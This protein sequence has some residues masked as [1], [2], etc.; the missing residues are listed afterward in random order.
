VNPPGL[1]RRELLALASVMTVTCRYAIRDVE[2]GMNGVEREDLRGQP[3]AVLV[4]GMH[5]SG[6]ALLARIIALLSETA[7]RKPVVPGHDGIPR[8]AVSTAVAA[9]NRRMLEEIGSD[10]HSPR[11]LFLPGKSIAE[12]TPVIRDSIQARYLDLAVSII[13]GAGATAP[14]IL[15]DPCLCLFSDL[16]RAALRHAGYRVRTV[17]AARNPLEVAAA[18]R[19]S[20]RLPANGAL[21]VWVRY[22]LT[23]LT[24]APCDQ[25][26]IVEQYGDLL[27]PGVELAELL[28]SGLD[29][30]AAN[31]A[32]NTRAAEEWARLIVPGMDEGAISSAVVARSPLVPS[33]VKR[34]HVL[35]TEWDARD[36]AAREVELAE[37]A[38]S[39]EDQ[40]LFAG[41]LLQV[42]LPE[43]DKPAARCIAPGFGKAR[44]VLVH[45]HL[46]KNAGS[47]VDAILQRNFGDRWI[48]EEF[49]PARL[50]NHQEA[51]HR[52]IL[53]NPD[54]AAV[55]SHTLV[56]PPPKI[57]G[58][59]IFPILFVRHPLDRLKSAYEFERKQE[60]ANFGA[61]L[62]R[63]H[64][65][66]GYVRGRLAIPR[67]R[68][69]RDFHVMRLAMA[70]PVQEGTERERAL[71]ALD[72][73]PFVGLVEA[74]AASAQV[75]QE[76]VRR[77]FPDFQSFESW[78]NSGR[79]R[80]RSLEAR[81]DAIRQELGEEC[82]ALAVEANKEDMILYEAARRRYQVM[83][84]E[85]RR[86]I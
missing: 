15:E 21:K 84:E 69:C 54:M 46:F 68:S 34:L 52:V 73:L 16:W 19:A 45:Y 44:K 6:T 53:D 58:V 12:S 71:M 33:L 26:L 32:G 7:T 13:C 83:A 1:S 17:L 8:P 20:H 82:F 35:L 67:D 28:R 57:E 81:L 18:L 39:F 77:M 23:L 27:K 41:N 56:L 42:R 50:V 78:E 24:S 70:V 38:A 14:L 25:D 86:P 47:S 2:T 51:I 66:A 37:L 62:A 10:W 29:L 49:P 22:N 30:P 85:Q 72:R 80:E 5:A 11:L 9:L 65:F 74:F 60:G 3:A 43:P 64:D 4:T 40:S 76:Q 59:E 61:R 48:K 55:S 31:A 79:P 36:A 75:L 63:E